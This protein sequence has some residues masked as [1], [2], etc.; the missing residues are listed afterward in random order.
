MHYGNKF[1]IRHQKDYCFPRVPSRS[2]Q[3]SSGFNEVFPLSST[4]SVIG[5]GKQPNNQY[6]TQM[7]LTACFPSQPKLQTHTAVRCY[8]EICCSLPGHKSQSYPSPRVK[9]KIQHLHIYYSGNKIL[10]HMVSQV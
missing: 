1:Y 10:Q 7:L 2:P 9:T 5:T 3:V 6:S 8:K 4:K